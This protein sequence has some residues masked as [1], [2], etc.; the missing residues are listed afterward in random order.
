MTKVNIHKLV[1]LANLSIPEERLTKLE[2]QLDTTIEHVERLNE[3]NTDNVIG[4]NEVTDLTNC[5]REDEVRPSLTQEEAL[6]N[7]KKT[8]NG[9]FVVPVIIEEAVE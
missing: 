2:Q 4:T 7:A 6:Q 5:A 3:V 1:K 9:F 8:H